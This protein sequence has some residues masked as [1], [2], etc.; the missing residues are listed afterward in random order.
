MRMD[1]PSQGLFLDF[2]VFF[3]LEFGYKYPSAGRNFQAVISKIYWQDYVFCY[4]DKI[5]RHV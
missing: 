1:G 4:D 5:V 3:Q 2:L